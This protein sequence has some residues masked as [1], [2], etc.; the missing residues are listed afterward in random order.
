MDSQIN[1]MQTNM[2]LLEPRVEQ[3]ASDLNNLET[4][5]FNKMRD[6]ELSAPPAK[7]STS[8]I[9]QCPNCYG[10]GRSLTSGKNC[11]RCG[12]TGKVRVR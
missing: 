5:I 3:V 7:P 10:M 6:I 11:E 8:D 1:R 9:V 2:R 12:G 4:R